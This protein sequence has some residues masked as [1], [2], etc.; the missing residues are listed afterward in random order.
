MADKE[1]WAD[2]LKTPDDF[3]EP[4]KDLPFRELII[5]AAGVMDLALEALLKKLLRHDVADQAAL[6]EGPDAALGAFS[7]RIRMAYMTCIIS[8]PTEAY[9]HALRDARNTCAHTVS[10]T[11]TSGKLSS[12]LQRIYDRWFEL[13]ETH[14][15]STRVAKYRSELK[16]YQTDQERARYL[17]LYSMVTYHNL[18]Q[19][20]HSILVRLEEQTAIPV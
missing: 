13:M 4:Y 19:R 1:K 14:G 2:I 3:V 11:L 12:A 20:R 8:K 5:V 9:L 16:D 7:R 6:F 17:V 18:L 15:D 10:L